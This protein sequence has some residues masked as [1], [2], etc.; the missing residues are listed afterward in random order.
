MSLQ[1]PLLHTTLTRSSA[2]GCTLGTY[3]RKDN[4][5][6]RIPSLVQIVPSLLQLIFIW[7]V[8]E[9]PRWLISKERH[10]EALEI[11]IKYHGEG[12]ET[13]F[14]RAEYEEIQQR[15]RLEMENSKRKWVELIATPGN[16]RRVLIAI[17]VGTFSQ[18]SGNG[19]VSYY[20]AKVL[21]TVGI[22]DK[23]TQNEINLGLTCTNLVTGICG[24]FLTK[25]LPRR[26]QYLIAFIGMTSKCLVCSGCE[27]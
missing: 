16:R 14:V 24:A 1:S 19:L 25:I 13:D 15:I 10:E 27:W 17:C 7:F 4:W 5:A 26:K 9:S 12:V 21:N 22:T 18:W 23:R 2:A 6:W 3:N 20:L 8:P 11:L